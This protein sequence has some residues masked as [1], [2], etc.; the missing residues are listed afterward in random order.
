MIDTD[1]YEAFVRNRYLIEHSARVLKLVDQQHGYNQTD[2]VRVDELGFFKVQH[3]RFRQTVSRHPH[4]KYTLS[5]EDL[6]ESMCRMDPIYSRRSTRLD[7]IFSSGDVRGTLDDRKMAKASKARE[8]TMDVNHALLERVRERNRATRAA[9]REEL[10]NA[11]LHYLL[12][13]G[14]DEEETGTSHLRGLLSTALASPS[15]GK[16]LSTQAG[17][18]IR[19]WF[20]IWESLLEIGRRQRLLPTPTPTSSITTIRVKALAFC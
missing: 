3:M 17:Q 4:L 13:A 1:D 19:H 6:M 7:V 16:F 15:V 18:S 5:E 14:V 9:T 8:E 20:S 10:M 12:A 2:G 11:M